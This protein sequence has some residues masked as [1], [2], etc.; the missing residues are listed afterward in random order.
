MSTP[1]NPLINSLGG[2]AGFGENVLDRNDDSSTE[3]ID[4][5]SVFE[6]GL[7]FFGTAYNGFYI[8]N[9]G[10]ITFNNPSSTYTPFAITGSTDRPIVAPFFTDIDTRAGAITASLGGNSTGS[11]LVYWDLDPAKDTVTIT[12]DDVGQYASGTTPNAFQMRLKDTGGGNFTIEFRYEDIQWNRGDARAGYSAA[13]GSNFFELP[14]SGTSAM[15]DLETASNIEQ[16]GVFLFSVVNGIPNQPPTDINLSQSSINENSSNG[17]VIGTLTTTDPDAG[18]LHTYTLLD[19]AD[20]RFAINGNQLVV[21]S[22]AL[23][24]FETN[25]SYN[26]TVRTRDAASLTYD[27]S[28]TITLNNVPEPDL[29]FTAATAPD[30]ANLG[31]TIQVNWAVTNQGDGTALAD[32]VDYVYISDDQTLDGSDIFVNSISAAAFSPLAPNG[33]YSET[34]NITIPNTVLG[35]RYLLFVADRDNYQREIDETNNIRAV[36]ITLSAPDLVVSSITT[37]IETL[38]GQSVEIAWTV[39]NQG[40]V[41]ATG[42]WTDYIYLS[43]DA[44]AGGDRFIAAFPFSGTIA[45]GASVERRQSITVPLELSGNYRVVVTTDEFGQ[46]PEGSANESNNTAIDDQPVQVQLSPIPNLQ[47]TNVT[48]PPTAFSGQETVIQWTVNNTGNGATS[49]PIWYDEV[50]LSL[51]TTFDNT[52]V[53]LGKVANPSYLNAEDSYVNSLSAKLPQGID[54]NYYFLVKTDRDNQVNELQNEGDNF[55][56][57]APTAVSPGILTFSATEFSVNE[58]GTAIAAVSVTRTGR[59]TGE[60]SATVTPTAGTATSSTDYDNAPIEVR[61]ADGETTKTVA[62]P[63]VDDALVEGNETINLTLSAPTGGATIGE[64]STAIFTIV[65]NDTLSGGDGSTLR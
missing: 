24:D 61:F 65:D 44:T 33:S 43:S 18:D 34:Q 35:N 32:W 46:L 2:S 25:P 30:T 3:L 38:S 48:A 40:S 60:V 39:T 62:V 16:P 53:S 28:F 26:I 41:D 14:Q 8:N 11:N 27:E 4:V 19:D 6:S 47:V 54:G 64:Q 10:N 52:D 55:G 57:G 42:S 49:A 17:T 37:P 31:Q 59:S 23:L 20:G 29:Q 15:L 63:I 36:P 1:D 13:N 9:N 51:D 22:S 58:D 45:A 7:N 5:T 50:Y 12:W 21:A 56:V